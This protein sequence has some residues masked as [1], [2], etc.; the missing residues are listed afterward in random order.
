MGRGDRGLRA[1][2]SRGLRSPQG[3]TS[4]GPVHAPRLDFARVRWRSRARSVVRLAVLFVAGC[5]LDWKET[6]FQS[7]EHL[8]G[9][10]F[11]DLGWIP[12]NLVPKGAR[13]I[14]EVHNIDTNEV[15]LRFDTG[16]ARLGW[17]DGSWSR[18]AQLDVFP[19]SRRCRPR[20]WWSAELAVACETGVAPDRT[21]TIYCRGGERLFLQADRSAVYYLR[22]GQDGPCTPAAATQ[23]E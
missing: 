22:V 3:L 8:R 5:G 16:Q 12:K 4:T 10:A 18:T 6:S 15:W 7:E 14:R 2:R 20:D 1:G 11:A 23:R 19:A 9:S 21:W 13:D 17:P